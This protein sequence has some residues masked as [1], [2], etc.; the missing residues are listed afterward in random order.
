MLVN[1][2]QPVRPNRKCA[3]YA[4]HIHKTKNQVRQPLLDRRLPLDTKGLQGAS[5]F[6]EGSRI[7][8]I[9]IMKTTGQNCR[10]NQEIRHQQT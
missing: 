5:H 2:T 6:G 3:V 7:T 8:R 1:L 9:I 4:D 10:F